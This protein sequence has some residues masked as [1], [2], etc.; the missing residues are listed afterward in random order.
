M[1]HI[2]EMA[3]SSPV[4]TMV[5]ALPAISVVEIIINGFTT[6]AGCG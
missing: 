6:L 4:V 3:R 1:K 2:A 5:I